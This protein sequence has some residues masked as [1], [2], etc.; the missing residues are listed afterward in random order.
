VDFEALKRCPDGPGFALPTIKAGNHARHQHFGFQNG[1]GLEFEKVEKQRFVKAPRPKHTWNSGSLPDS[2][3]RR[4]FNVP[5][6]K[7]AELMEVAAWEALDR[8][9]LSFN[10]YYKETIH[11]TNLYNYRVRKV[12]LN[13]FL[14]DET[15]QMTEP[16]QDNSG[17]PQGTLIRRHRFPDKKGGF[18][19]A[20]DVRIGCD[21]T[22]Y[23]K[24]IRITNC[25]AF[26]RKYFSELGTEQP[27]AVPD[28]F[29]P[30]ITMREEA[31]SKQAKQ[32]RSEE[33][34]YREALLGGSRA[35]ADMQQF[36]E[37]DGK[38]LRFYA[39]LDDMET[40]QFERRPFILLFFLADDTMEIRELYPGNCGREN[41]PIFYRR[42][43]MPRGNV[44][45]H[46]PMSKPKQKDEFVHGHE[47]YVGQTVELSSSRFHIH[48]ADEFTRKYFGELGIALL[49][50]SD[51][52]LPEFTVPRAATPPYTG[53]GSWEDSMASVTDL[54][55]KQPKKDMVKIFNN[56]GKVYRFTARFAKPVD[57]L[58][59]LFIFNFYPSDDTLMVHEPPQRNL[60][61]VT[62]RFLEKGLH[63]NLETGLRIQPDDLRPGKIVKINSH[64]FEML[65]MD[66][67]TEKCIE[68]PEME[69]TTFDLAVVM[70][71]L[72]DSMRQ[73]APRIRDIFRRFDSDHNGVLTLPEFKQALSKY[74]FQ[75]SNE[76]AVIVMKHFDKR[77]DGQVDYI[78]FCNALLDADYSGK[79]MIA[80]PSP[81]TE[82]RPS[83]VVYA[84]KAMAKSV[85]RQ[86]TEDVRRAVIYLGDMVHKRHAT[87]LRNIFKEFERITTGHHVSN[88]QIK[89]A[90][91][92]KGIAM[93][94]EDI[95]R[96]IFFVY[97]DGD[98]QK[99]PY[100]EF[101]KAVV[102]SFHD[103]SS[104]R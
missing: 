72:Q 34:L 82:R 23:G 44:E 38:V 52:G 76:E 43:K 85:D 74:S 13:Y 54:I 1:I 18:L 50:K 79:M 94:L 57:N 89:Y 12:V 17:I 62:G 47:L 37:N 60:G 28:E 35:N 96:A 33:Q 27:E 92:V 59:R 103:M 10:G 39:N 6:L 91:D 86:E 22:I 83:K 4:V 8:H 75:I 66:E 104:V 42:S 65:E 5:E 16:R 98:L 36:L 80:K 84:E 61:L 87:V 25:D 63:V 81:D 95:D 78:Q 11:E 31:K 3:S 40:P 26:T 21:F 29:D 100:V 53:Y 49:P 99:V 14:Q 101:F 77:G 88:E 9:V 67:F 68:H 70:E 19:K 30:W 97:P 71:K 69:H 58:N 55:P 56:Q 15:F 102:A 24:T 32:P 2:H 93:P 90:L 45:L 20:E 64:V 7:P 41:Y 51:M 46:T 73:H 48:D